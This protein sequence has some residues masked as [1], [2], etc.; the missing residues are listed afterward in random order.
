MVWYWVCG[1]FV[2]GEEDECSVHELFVLEERS[3]EGL[4]PIRGIVKTCVVSIV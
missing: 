2:V 4:C 1:A 3:E